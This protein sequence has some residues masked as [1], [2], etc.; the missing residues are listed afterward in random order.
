[1]RSHIHSLRHAVMTSS[2]VSFLLTTSVSAFMVSLVSADTWTI[3]EITQGHPRI[4]ITATDVSDIADAIAQQ[5]EPRYSIW[6]ELQYRADV[7]SQSTDPVVPYIGED[8]LV[9]FEAACADERIALR[10][11]VIV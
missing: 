7:W 3:P 11:L 9:F 8:S 2:A 10:P 5:Q 6:M 1:M 4:Q